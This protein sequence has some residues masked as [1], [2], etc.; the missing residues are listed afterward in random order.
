MPDRYYVI[1]LLLVLTSFNQ[2]DVWIFWNM[3]SI[4]LDSQEV[5][6]KMTVCL[7][8]LGLTKNAVLLE[9]LATREQLFVG[10]CGA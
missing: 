10:S 9:N 2:H 5:N 3:I 6:L 8:I 4:P 7:Q 1:R